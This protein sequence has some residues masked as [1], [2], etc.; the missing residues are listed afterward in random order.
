MLHLC[1]IILKL[2]NLPRS[3]EF[4]GA[5]S[6]G[7]QTRSPGEES[8]TTALIWALDALLKKHSRFTVAQLSRK[9][10]EAPNFP[11][12]QVP[13]QLDRCSNAIERIVLA[14]LAETDDK[15]EGT[16]NGSNDT[17]EN[18]GHL[19]LNFV[20]DEA[21]SKSTVRKFAESL[22]LA[23]RKYEIPVKRIGWGGFQ[24]P[25]NAYYAAAKMFKEGLNRKKAKT[26]ADENVPVSFLGPLTPSS[27]T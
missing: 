11:K 27:G 16:P 20:F 22:D 13:V 26:E 8:F 1:E 25:R 5:C 2:A 6:S 23:M 21:L 10:R 15:T 17:N 3:F 24:P 14:P 7:N 4:L 9:I 12:G 19:T 18:Q